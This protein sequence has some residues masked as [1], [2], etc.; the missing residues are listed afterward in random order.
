MLVVCVPLTP[1]SHKHH[2]FRCTV[3]YCMMISKNTYVA[4]SRADCVL[5]H[6]VAVNSGEL[7]LTLRSEGQGQRSSLCSMEAG[8][9]LWERVA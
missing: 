9:P 5:K 7:F 4:Y 6:S 8:G 2:V 1:F 3:L